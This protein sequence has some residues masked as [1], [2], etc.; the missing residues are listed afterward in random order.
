MQ[1]VKDCT[2]GERES[3]S[4]LGNT[5]KFCSG[6]GIGL[7]HFWAYPAKK[8]NK[9]LLCWRCADANNGSE[10]YEKVHNLSETARAAVDDLN[11]VDEDLLATD[12]T[13]NL[14]LCLLTDVPTLRIN[15]FEDYFVQDLESESKKLGIK[16]QDPKKY[17]N[18]LIPKLVS[19][20]TV[21]GQCWERMK[22]RYTSIM[23]F[24]APAGAQSC[25]LMCMP[26]VDKIFV[27]PLHRDF[28]G[29]AAAMLTSSC[30]AYSVWAFLPFGV[31]VNTKDSDKDVLMEVFG[32][33]ELADQLPRQGGSL[34]RAAD[35]NSMDNVV[36]A[37]RELLKIDC[38]ILIDQK[39]GEIV[40][41]GPGW[42]H[43]VANK[44]ASIKVASDKINYPQDVAV[45]VQQHQAVAGKMHTSRRVEEGSSQTQEA[46]IEFCMH[47]FL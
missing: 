32:S 22:K 29:G 16:L 30:D 17:E 38:A 42:V 13:Q 24:S 1:Q 26:S 19:D 39:P 20:E 8:G 18:R 28:M 46:V 47:P 37:L 27:T 3:K 40:E 23:P 14:C 21:I 45:C 35:S 6:C 11:K 36:T 12:Y 5:H 15:D 33:S 41:F 2:G 7:C 44:G 25:S 34:M 10:R 43:V 31:F 4:N 9:M